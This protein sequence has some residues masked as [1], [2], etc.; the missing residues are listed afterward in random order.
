MGGILGTD[1]DAV[2]NFRF[3]VAVLDVV[4]QFPD[5][6][7]YRWPNGCDVF[8]V[9]AFLLSVAPA[10]LDPPPGGGGGGGGGPCS[11]CF[12]QEGITCEAIGSITT[13]PQLILKA[14]TETA[15]FF[16]IFH[17]RD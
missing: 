4:K 6:H 7:R 2:R 10:D 1:L 15:V 3:V 13:E 11:T 9:M 5:R 17:N 16:G 12:Q 14:G 8:P